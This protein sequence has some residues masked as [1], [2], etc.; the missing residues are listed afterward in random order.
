MEDGKREYIVFSKTWYVKTAPREEFVDEVT[1]GL[2]ASDG[3]TY[4]EAKMR[5]YDL[6]GSQEPAAHLEVFQ[7]AWKALMSFDDLLDKLGS[8]DDKNMTRDEFVALLEECGFTD[9]TPTKSPY[10]KEEEEAAASPAP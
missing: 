3:G 5:W 9:R 8:L 1:F 10:A 6:G 7:D 2:F 4:G